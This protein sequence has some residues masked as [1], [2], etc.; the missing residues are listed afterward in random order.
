MKK[1]CLLFLIILAV[2][3][4]SLNASNAPSANA[5]K[6]VYASGKIFSLLETAFQINPQKNVLLSPLSLQQCF[7]MI[8]CGASPA[9]AA[10]LQEQFYR[11]CP[12]R[13]GSSP[14]GNQG[15]S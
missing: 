5:E 13:T 8:S 4:I 3:I 9:A 1:I 11:N 6:A 15:I 7:G 12:L 2:P 14:G 10:E